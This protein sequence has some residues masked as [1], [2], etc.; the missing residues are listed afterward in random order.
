MT[1]MTFFAKRAARN[2]KLSGNVDLSSLVEMLPVL[3]AA[4]IAVLALNALV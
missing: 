1:T 2:A 3:V 4:L